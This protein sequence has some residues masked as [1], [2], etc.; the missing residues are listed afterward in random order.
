MMTQ[1][2]EQMRIVLND[3]TLLGISL[4]SWA[5]FLGLLVGLALLFRILMAVAKVRSRRLADRSELPLHDYLCQILDHTWPISIVALAAYLAQTLVDF[6]GS[7]DPTAV[8]VGDTIR[9]LSLIVLFLQAG[10]WGMGLIDEGL[11]HGFRFANFSESAARTAHGVVRFFALA[12]LWGIILIL[13]LGSFGVE[14]TPLLAGLGVGGIAVAFALQQILGDIFCSVA[15]VLDKPFEVGDFIITGD[16]MGVVEFIGVKT[17]RVRSLGGEQIVFPN[18]D[19]IGSR[20]R[21]YKR[22]AERRVTFGFGVR[23]DTPA[24]ILQRIPEEVRETIESLDQVRF[25]RA[26]F[27]KFGDSSLDFEVVYYVLSPDYNQ[28]MDLQQSINL[29]LMRRMESL[30]VEFAFPSRSLYVEQ[31]A[32]RSQV[33][34]F[35]G[36]SS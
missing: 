5:V 8:A 6:R 34:G 26:H 19:L 14:I 9:A 13:I 25:D 21:N 2:W 33:S 11:T 31:S 29:S 3:R 12:G 20:V 30:G 10:R 32:G 7:I 27:A 35:T 15:I 24:D 18:S 22:M 4:G 16:H 28:Y 36:T 23:Y 1:T 17:T